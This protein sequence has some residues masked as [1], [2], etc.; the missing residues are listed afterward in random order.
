[1]QNIIALDNYERLYD[2]DLAIITSNATLISE[3][4]TLSISTAFVLAI[5]II[6]ISTSLA[7]TEVST[8]LFTT[9]LRRNRRLLLS[10]SYTNIII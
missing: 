4:S 2:I 3:T 10:S 5:I 1:M 6:K 7:I 9:L 8:S